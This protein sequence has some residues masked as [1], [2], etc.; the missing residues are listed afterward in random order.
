MGTYTVPEFID[1]LFRE[2]KPKTLVFSHWKQAFWACFR[3]NWVYN[4]RHSS[5]ARKL[6]PVHRGEE[7]PCTKQQ[8]VQTLTNCRDSIELTRALIQ[9]KKKRERVD[10]CLVNRIHSFGGWYAF[11]GFSI[12]SLVQKSRVPPLFRINF[13]IKSRLLLKPFLL[14]W[15][16]HCFHG[17]SRFFEL[18]RKTFVLIVT[19]G[20]FLTNYFEYRLRPRRLIRLTC[21]GGKKLWIRISSKL[22]IQTSLQHA[23]VDD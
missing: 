17:M 12:H 18:T 4:F 7:F 21:L 20:I 1:P 19:T 23:S 2:N 10:S 13:S 15:I 9:N 6:S 3:E 8:P 14:S 11:P 22:T 16:P 5:R